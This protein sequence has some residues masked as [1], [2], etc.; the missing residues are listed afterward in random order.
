M[1]CYPIIGEGSK[2][3]Q[4]NGCKETP[5]IAVDT[6]T[7]AG[8]CKTSGTSCSGTDCCE[9]GSRWLGT[10]A[11]KKCCESGKVLNNSD[12]ADSCGNNKIA[13]DDGVCRDNTEEEECTGDGKIWN[14]AGDG[15]CCESGK[16]PDGANCRDAKACPQWKG[17]EA[18]KPNG[19]VTA[20][21]CD[22]YASDK[23]AC[24]RALRKMQRL[25]GQIAKA[26]KD[27]EGKEDERWEQ[28]HGDKE[29][30]KTEAGGLCWS[31]L[32]SALNASRPSAG[33]QL[34]N[35][36][37]I[38]G[39]AG[40]SLIG[41]N[42]GRRAQYDA[43]QLRIKRGGYAAQNDLYSFAGARAGFPFVHRGIYGMTK[44]GTPSG[45]WSCSPSLN[46]PS[47]Y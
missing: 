9:K 24:K 4:D 6:N 34:G 45:G 40:L 2:S 46:S 16:I 30:K 5:T 14:S 38:L 17:H 10:G 37:S 15:Q 33:Q 28:R 3:W 26:E 11:N 27:L 1:C 20:A 21:F 19:K 42:M 36:L 29:E 12:C 44:V 13:G 22:T 31:C 47:Y 25:A 43:N 39:G 35:A 8:T 32:K 18:F 23:R 41:Y 7:C